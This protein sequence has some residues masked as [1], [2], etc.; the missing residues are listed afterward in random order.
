MITSKKTMGAEQIAKER[1]LF[2][3]WYRTYRKQEMTIE[4]TMTIESDP[5]IKLF[6]RKGNYYLYGHP[7]SC[8]EAWIA[9]SQV[10]I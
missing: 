4:S 5:F 6:T 9:R 8:W 10:N 2:E 7:N 3:A 1:A